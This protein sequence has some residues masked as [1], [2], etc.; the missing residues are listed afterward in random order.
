MGHIS[1]IHETSQGEIHGSEIV[2]MQGRRRDQTSQLDAGSMTCSQASARP[3][4][5]T[6]RTDLS[7]LSK[8]FGKTVLGETTVRN[9][10]ITGLNNFQITA[11]HQG[12]NADGLN[13]WRLV[14]LARMPFL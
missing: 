8:R 9:Q 14:C 7:L 3:D 4:S 6:P 11:D 1:P 2:A 5:R 12:K 13:S 10:P